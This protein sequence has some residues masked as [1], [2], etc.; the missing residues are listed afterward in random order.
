MWLI[1]SGGLTYLK[2][3]RT[4]AH[5]EHG[6]ANGYPS[7][8][9][10]VMLAA[11]ARFPSR[12]GRYDLIT[13]LATGGRGRVYRGR[14]TGIGGFERKVVIKTL[15]VPLTA[16]SDPAIA[17]F[18][19]EARVLALLHHQHIASVFEVGRDDEGRCFMVLEYVEGV[20]AHDVWERAI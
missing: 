17:M 10:A 16:E 12:I 14:A 9:S 7:S 11:V 4:R 2:V 18:L 13:A 6:R 5:A 8:C 20:S 19:D 3:N 1:S 15:E